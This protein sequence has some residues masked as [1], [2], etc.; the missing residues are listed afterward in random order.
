M[1]HTAIALLAC[2]ETESPLCGLIW[3]SC[4]QGKDGGLPQNSTITGKAY[5]NEIQLDEVAAPILLAWRLRRADALRQFDPW[6][7]VSRA[8]RYLIEHGPVTGQER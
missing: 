1:V 5:W 7:I 2:D 3:L 4:V 6:I 8:A